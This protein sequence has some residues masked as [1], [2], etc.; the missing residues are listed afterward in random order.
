MIKIMRDYKLDI[1][2]VSECLWMG[3]GTN[4]V[5]DGVEIL[6]SGMPE[7]GPH[8]HGVALIL[9]P[10]TAKSL[11]AFRPVN[12]RMIIARLQEKHGS[13]TVMRCYAPI[14]G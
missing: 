3:S 12:E 10:N 4:R 6:Y 7:G 8:V 9:S 2:G 14:K 1:L 11:L 13:M 5:G